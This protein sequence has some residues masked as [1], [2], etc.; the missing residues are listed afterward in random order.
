MTVGGANDVI[1]PNDIWYKFEHITCHVETIIV[2]DSFKLQLQTLIDSQKFL[3][4]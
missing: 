4:L 2:P 1:L 3:P